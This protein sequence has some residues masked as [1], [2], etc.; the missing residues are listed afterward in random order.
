MGRK[1]SILSQCDGDYQHNKIMEMLVVKFLH[2]TLTDVIIPTFDMRLLQPISFSTLK[3]KRNASKVS[4]LSD[5]CIG[6]SAAPYY[7]PPYY[8]EMHASTGTKKFNLVDG[9]AANIPVSFSS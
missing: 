8:F 7:L 6:T 1:R 9:V 4:W 5:N 2:Q 3:A